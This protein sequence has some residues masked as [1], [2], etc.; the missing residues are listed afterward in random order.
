MT[1]VHFSA[2]NRQIPDQVLTSPR[3]NVFEKNNVRFRIGGQYLNDF[4]DKGIKNFIKEH[5]NQKTG[6]LGSLGLGWGGQD[7]DF[8]EVKAFIQATAANADKVQGV[9]FELTDPELGLFD[10]DDVSVK[11]IK[12]S[13]NLQFKETPGSSA[14]EVSFVDVTGATYDLKIAK[15]A[16]AAAKKALDKGRGTHDLLQKEYDRAVE[17]RDS[18]AKTIGN[19]AMKQLGEFQE[20]LTTTNTR[21]SSLDQEIAKARQDLSA[22]TIPEAQRGQYSHMIRGMEA[23]KKDLQQELTNIRKEMGK[24]HGFWSFMGGGESLN[25]LFQANEVVKNARI[26]LEAHD[27]KSGF[28]QLQAAYDK[29]VERRKAVEAGKSLAEVDPDFARAQAISG[30]AEPATVDA[31]A[32]P[33]T[34]GPSIAERVQ[35]L[36]QKSPAEQLEAVASLNP[37]ERMAMLRL[38]DDYIRAADDSNPL[39][40]SPAQFDSLKA[41][42]PAAQSL[43]LNLLVTADETTQSSYLQTLS[44]RQKEELSAQLANQVIAQRF[45]QQAE[46]LRNRLAS[47]APEERLLPTA[48]PMPET[49]ADTPAPTAE[50][51]TVQTEPPS[52]PVAP[53]PADMPVA[54]M[55]PSGPSV[56]SAPP[57]V[58]PAQPSD[59]PAQPTVGPVVAEPVLPTEVVSAP[60]SEAP[61]TPPPAPEMPPVVPQTQPPVLPVAEEPPLR[62]STVPAAPVASQPE[63]PPLRRPEQLPSAPPAPAFEASAFLKLSAEEQ[64]EQF[65]ALPLADQKKAFARMAPQQ[66]AEQLLNLTLSENPGS[67][68]EQLMALLNQEQKVAVAGVLLESL[69]VVQNDYPHIAEGIFSVLNG[70]GV[71]PD[72]VPAA[73]AVTPAV[74]TA[75]PLDPAASDLSQVP[76][77]V[78]QPLA[79]DLQPVTGGAPPPADLSGKI[80]ELEPLLADRSW[81]GFGG[82]NK[83]EQVMT[84]SE[85]VWTQ[86]TQANRHQLANVLVK[87]NNAAELARILANQAVTDQE[88]GQILTHPQFALKEY[89]NAIDDS[90]ATLMLISLGRLAG[91]GDTK[92]GDAIKATAAAYSSGWDRETPLKNM[93]TQLQSESLWNKIPKG[94]RDS[95]DNVFNSWWN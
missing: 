19:D 17:R 22:G 49:P 74:P 28:A 69:P 67:A 77:P 11:D 13:F 41:L 10:D 54:P 53:Q 73:P 24:T 46:A 2:H 1:G 72:Q 55:P 25:D 92:A 33:P 16:E 38:A 27:E 43:R 71:N 37:E 94:V 58:M 12:S 39:G 62:P 45:A 50:A 91:A 56:A 36:L 29:A 86:G 64:I 65:P 59:P 31:P 23:E 70:L 61:F 66:R 51:P 5:H 18:M 90:K 21:I 3:D 14:T 89:M 88:V 83:P 60:I 79:V 7:L 9:T 34:G 8:K 42:K 87:G 35:A 95:V 30:A 20:R 82:V 84:L 52:Q 93:Q 68:R 6:F 75:A 57:P 80:K 15:D 4:S 48:E 47:Q 81:M 40:L 85:E 76:A 63:E 32:A 78:V 26:R 44:Q